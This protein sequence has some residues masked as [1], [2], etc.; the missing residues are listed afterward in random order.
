[1]LVMEASALP[2]KALGCMSHADEAQDLVRPCVHACARSVRRRRHLS[3]CEMRMAQYMHR[4]CVSVYEEMD[5]CMS[6]SCGVAWM[7]CS[8]E[9]GCNEAIWRVFV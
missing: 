5:V 9:A 2:C 3:V 4:L 8:S 6:K 1:M 7:C